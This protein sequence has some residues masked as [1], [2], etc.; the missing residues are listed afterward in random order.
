MCCEVCICW[1][2]WSKIWGVGH[3]GKVEPPKEGYAMFRQW[4]NNVFPSAYLVCCLEGE[5]ADVEP[6]SCSRAN[7]PQGRSENRQWW[8]SNP[9][10]GRLGE[11][12][13]TYLQFHREAKAGQ[14]QYFTHLQ[15]WSNEKWALGRAK[16]LTRSMVARESKSSSQYML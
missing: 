11:R 7:Q 13:F 14:P 6:R 1:G 9:C 16:S 15:Y 4:R 3:C 5:K 8:L 12:T 10:W 2:F